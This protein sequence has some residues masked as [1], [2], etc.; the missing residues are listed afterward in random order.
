MKVIVYSAIYGAY[1]EIRTLLLR[2]KPTLFTDKYIDNKNWNIIVKKKKLGSPRMNAKYF[3]CNP[4]KELDC[5]VS[6]YID[7]SATIHSAYFVKFCLEQLGNAD[8]MA[9]RHHERDCIYDEADYCKDLEKYKNVDILKQVEKYRQ[10][11]Y[12]THAGLWACGLL[13]RRH[14]KKTKKFNELWWKHIRQYTYQDQL[15]FPVCIKE[16]G[17]KL[18]TL[19]LDLNNNKL[20][21]FLTPH[22]SLQ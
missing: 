17:V 4:H 22:A 19:E 20:I 9:F 10:D 2:E 18:K 5:D 11:G 13:V 6:I 15:S 7:G 1:D 14:N 16:S 21:T 8:I 12:P 3:K